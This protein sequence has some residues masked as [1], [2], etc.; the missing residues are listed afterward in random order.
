MTDSQTPLDISDAYRIRDL[1]RDRAVLIAALETLEAALK[2]DSRD[3][4]ILAD[5]VE[6]HLDGQ[7]MYHAI[8]TARATLASVKGDS[9]E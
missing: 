1:E 8:N 5:T 9:H 4:S 2:T 3:K 6:Y 7:A